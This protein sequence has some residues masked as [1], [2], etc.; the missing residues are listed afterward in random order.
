MQI[1]PDAPQKLGIVIVDHGSRRAE[2]N[3]LLLEIVQQFREASD[4][5]IVEPAHM[6]LAEPSIA[7]AFAKCAQQGA[8]QIVVHPYFLSPGRH[9]HEDIPNLAAEAAANHPGLRYEVTAPLGPHPLMLKIIEER[10]E[11]CLGQG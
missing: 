10:I 1:S 9:W 7:D 11:D 4:Y 6:E 5:A 2:S 3:D 8:T